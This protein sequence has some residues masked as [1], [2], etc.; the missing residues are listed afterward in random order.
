MENREI[1]SL[2]F[3]SSLPFELDIDLNSNI[4]LGLFNNLTSFLSDE[5]DLTVKGEFDD[6]LLLELNN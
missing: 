6:E 2:N 3:Y 5:L 4:K 1:K